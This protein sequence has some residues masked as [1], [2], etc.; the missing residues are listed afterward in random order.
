[1]TLGALGMALQTRVI[2]DAKTGDSKTGGGTTGDGDTGEGRHVRV[3][4]VARAVFDVSGAGDTV[5]AVAALALAA[6]A[7]PAE[8]AALANHAAAVEVEKAGVATVSPAEIRAHVRSHRRR[9]C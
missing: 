6:G 7:L 4:A 5:T 1:V 8:A 2:C 9:S 3:P